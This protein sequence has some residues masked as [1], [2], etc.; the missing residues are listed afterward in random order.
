MKYTIHYQLKDGTSIADD[1]KGSALAGST[2]T[3]EAKAGDQL[4]EDYQS[5]YFP[6]TSSHSITMD[7]DN[8]AKNEYTF[9]YVPK[10][11]VEYTVRYLDKATGEP[12]VVN[13]QPTPDKTATTSNA[14]VTETFMQITGYAPDAYQKRLVLSANEAENVL[15]FW[16]TKDDVHAPVQII[17]WTQNIEG[18]D[19]TE[20]QSSTD[21]NGVI[22]KTYTAQQL[23][24][25]SGFE[26]NAGKSKTSGT[27]GAG[28]L[29]LNLY[30]D[31]IKYPYEFRFLEQGT[32]KQLAPLA[33]GTARYQAQVTET[34]PSI[35]GYT[36]V[37]AENQAINIAIEDPAGVAKKNVKTFY[38][39]EQ[40]VDIKY[41]AVGFG[42]LDNV[43]DSNVKV[44]SGTVQGS[45]PTA[46]E[47][48]KFVGWFEDA[49][50][51]KAVNQTWVGTGSKLT[52]QK[53]VKYGDKDGYG[54]KTYYAKFER[55]V[56]NLTIEKT[57]K[58]IDQ[59]QTFVFR[60]RGKNNNVDMQ[61]V[62]TGANKQVIKNLPVGDYTIT[63]DT[64]WSWKYTPVDGATQELKSDSIH[65]GVATVTFENKNNGTNW[66]TS[67]AK[68]INTWAGGN[69][70][71]KT[72]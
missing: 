67:L 12:V 11:K 53:S 66:L 13:G 50:C 24:N 27:V 41:V 48:Y 15:V 26:F 16:Y 1:T 18:E 62:I 3:F 72:K 71:E 20:Y 32:D 64:S 39:Q 55:D 10:A 22:G 45:T 35:P 36:L 34:A 38:Y 44:L 30:Y 2:K 4:N 29:V 19:Y 69:A 70:H 23:T 52:P 68:A 5:G 65:D 57:G 33:K 59:N 28:G 7:I 42:T 31:R 17:H 51:T 60:V 54:A 21:L 63:E 37:S 25:L 49:A 61:V 56:F 8:P 43:Q 14:V 46:N 9:V 40:T 47:G 6:E 58:N